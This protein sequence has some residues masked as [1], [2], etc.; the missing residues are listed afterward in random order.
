MLD[1]HS[2]PLSLYIH[3]PWC[4]QKCPYCDFNSHPVRGELS[5]TT[6]IE[7]LCR[8][9]R[10][11]L[12]RIENRP[13]HSIFIGGGT[14]SLFS[15]TAYEKLFQYLGQHC[16]ILPDAEITLEAN[17]GTVE[18]QRFTDYFQI[19]INRLSIGIQSLQ[20]DK[21]KSLGRIHDQRQALRAI[22]AARTAGFSNFNVDLMFGL[23][24]QSITDAV[25][26]LQQAI[27]MQPPHLSWY[28]LTLEPNTLFHKF[29]PP[30]PDD[31]FLWQMQQEGVA[32]LT[33]NTY[34]QYEVSAYSQKEHQSQH[35]LNY[36][37]FGDYLGI[38][39]G[40][41]SK[42]TDAKST[43][44]RH[45]NIKHPKLYMSSQSKIAEQHHLIAS[46]IP[47]EFM[48][49][50]LRLYRPIPIEL[51]TTRTGLT[52]DVIAEKLQK[53]TELQYMTLNESYFEVT[54]RGR[55]FLNEVLEIFM[56]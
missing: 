15:A 50:A 55:N 46:E 44:H 5:E 52:L 8:E 35:N 21:L 56:P 28:Q 10:D 45:S 47:L 30:L 24:N 54:E 6:Y 12:P 9:F 49:N 19:G 23:P 43:I 20:N 25:S 2:I 4:V 31:D 16:Q 13:I 7:N 37:L 51:F 41:H 22:D 11:K 1:Y 27:A 48:L 32:L 14:P 33:E 36:W 42:I 18:Q 39:A 40:A 26:D 29:P 3:V 17:P 53:A 38:G 34:Q